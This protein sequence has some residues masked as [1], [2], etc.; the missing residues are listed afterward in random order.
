MCERNQSG[1]GGGGGDGSTD[2]NSSIAVG[3]DGMDTLQHLPTVC[4]FNSFVKLYSI[5]ETAHRTFFV[6]IY[7]FWRYT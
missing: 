5:Y 4:V 1:N 2:D 6:Q 3:R 7:D